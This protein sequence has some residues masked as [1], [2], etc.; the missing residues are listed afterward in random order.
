MTMEQGLVNP[1]PSESLWKNGFVTF[2]SFIGFGCTPLLAY[3]VLNPFTENN[4]LKFG[5]ACIV[6]AVALIVLGLAK[7][8]ISGRK[9]TS[10]ISMV[11]LNGALAAGVA[12][13][14]GWLLT[15]VL[16]INA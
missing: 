2:I 10:S 8:K 12:Y 3:V 9:Y 15:N 5:A 6:T 16:H 7:A 11:L 13:L 1:D 14:I 4:R